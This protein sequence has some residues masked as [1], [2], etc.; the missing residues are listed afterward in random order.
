[1]TIKDI[2]AKVLKGET[3]TDEEK[4][5]AGSYDPQ[6]DIDTA[7]GSARR[8]AEAD[9]KTAKDALTAL[10][11]E[12]DA[13]KADNDPAK[14]QTELAKL[15]KR[16]EKLEADKKAAEDRAAAM[17]RTS[18]VRALAKEAGINPAKGVDSKTIDLLVD[19]I[20]KDVDLDDADAVKTAFDGFK[21]SN[22]GMIAAQG[23]GGAGVRGTPGCTFTGKN[24][25]AKD[26]FNLTEQLEMRRTNPALA[27]RLA[28]E[29]SN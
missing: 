1:M 5:F 11:A 20:M 10:Q 17:E 23:V 12:F 8:K 24:P 9:A 27:E 25:F 13:Y 4:T 6:K 14:G 21:T 26:T 19:H 16:M 3:L 7:A 22:A 18:R 15:T 28:S 2:I 29:A